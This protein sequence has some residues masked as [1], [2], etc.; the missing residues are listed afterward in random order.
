L[1]LLIKKNGG[2]FGH[3]QFNFL[4]QKKFSPTK[5]EAYNNKNKAFSQGFREHSL[6]SQKPC[7]WGVS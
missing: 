6:T 3:N 2:D 7:F 4:V 1:Q 5:N